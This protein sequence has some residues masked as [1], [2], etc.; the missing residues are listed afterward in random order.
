[1]AR[2]VFDQ[3]IPEQWGG[4]VITKARQVSAVERVA[5]REPM[6]AT[7]KHVPRSGGMTVSTAIPKGSAYPED[8]AANDTVLLNA[9]KFGD[10]LRVAQEDLADTA[11]VANIIQTKQLDWI[12]SYAVAYDNA[13]LGTTAAANGTTV[14]YTSVY[15]AVRT[16]NAATGYTAD[17]NYLNVAT[18]VAPKY[19]DVSALFGLV[20]NTN[21]YV[22]GSAVVIAHPAWKAYIRSMVDTQGRPVFIDSLNG[23]LPSLLGVPLVWSLGARASATMSSNPTGN[24]L[25]IVGNQ[26]F[27]ILGDR[28]PIEYQIAGADSGPAFLTDEALM[29]VRV[30]RGF[31]VGQESAFAVLEKTP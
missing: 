4:P 22:D 19:G 15:K 12:T 10:V 7:L 17:A 23:A 3:W 20:E 21:F 27:L 31:A 25:M 24:P 18:T 29:K 6:S 30:R 14:P 5:R 11:Q 8:T 13:C 2:Q 16:S 28:S 26:D 9:L 1:M